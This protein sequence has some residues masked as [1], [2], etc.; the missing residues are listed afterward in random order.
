MPPAVE[1]TM[2]DNVLCSSL[3]R[4]GF[5]VALFIMEKQPRK[6]FR[7]S[8][9]VKCLHSV[10][11]LDELPSLSQTYHL[12]RLLYAEQIHSQE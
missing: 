8:S 1:N 2:K 6:Q 12:E 5:S 4:I 7:A 10:G 9:I 11:R 3:Q